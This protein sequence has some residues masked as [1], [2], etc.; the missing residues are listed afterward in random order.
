[1]HC[2]VLCIDLFILHKL[3]LAGCPPAGPASVL[4]DWAKLYPI[5]L[6]H[7]IVQKKTALLLSIRTKHLKNSITF[8]H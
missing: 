6:T 3:S 1:M 8:V 7:Q 2:K 5:V 4:L